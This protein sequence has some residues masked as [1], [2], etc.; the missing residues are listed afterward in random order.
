MILMMMNQKP[1]PMRLKKPQI[2][3]RQPPRR[4]VCLPAGESKVVPQRLYERAISAAAS[5]TAK[6]VACG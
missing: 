1:N 6:Y 5:L 2:L 3:H 4:T